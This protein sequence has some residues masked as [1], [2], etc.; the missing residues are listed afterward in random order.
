MD[1]ADYQH[2]A[3]E[4]AIYP[5]S[6][7]LQGLAYVTLGLT[8]EAGEVANKVKK[9][10]RDHYGKTMTAEQRMM[11]SGELGDVL[12]YLAQACTELGADLG[13]I[14]AMNLAKLESRALRG[15]LQGD[16]D[17]R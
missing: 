12:W 17:Q 4:T 13:E 14:A 11:L 7:N 10:I 15:T 6:G 1:F 2:R 3:G 16:G 8:G 5:G 9:L